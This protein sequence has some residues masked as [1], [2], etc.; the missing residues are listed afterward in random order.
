MKKILIILLLLIVAIAGG[1]A[2]KSTLNTKT[3]LVYEPLSERERTLM[4]VT[5]NNVI[6]YKLKNIPKGKKY[7]I[8]MNYQV[9]ENDKKIKDDM[10]FSLGSGEI[11]TKKENQLIGIGFEDKKIRTVVCSN[12]GYATSTYNR[13]EYLN[14]SSTHFLKDITLESGD[15]VY[16]YYATTNNSIRSDLPLGVPIDEETVNKFLENG[17]STILIKLSY[18]EVV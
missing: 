18:K 16:L 17:K 10:M 2:I 3:E 1:L 13:K 11:T 5:G 14:Y 6:M 7:E 4:E 15:E 12:G 8:N 9:Y